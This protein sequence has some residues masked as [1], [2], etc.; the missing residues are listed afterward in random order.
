MSPSWRDVG[1][2]ALAP[3]SVS[4]LRFAR[5]WHPRLALKAVVPCAPGS[6]IWRAALETMRTLLA[7]PSWQGCDLSV[8]L[9]NHFVRYAVVPGDPGL[10]TP[11]ERTAFAEIAFEKVFGG[12]CADW[13]LRVSPA[14]GA[15][16]TLASGVDRALLA[17]LRDTCGGKARLKAIR[18]YLMCAFNPLRNA[19]NGEA[20]ALALVEPGRVTLALTA[21]S[22]WA[23]V[24]SRAAAQPDG[25]ALQQMLAEQCALS[26]LEARGR[27]WLHDLTGVCSLAPGSAW[28]VAA[29]KLPAAAESA[30]TQFGLA[31]C[32][33]A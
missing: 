4:A 23:S 21:R 27:L 28:N 26:G 19:L 15:E 8:V 12:L 20:S 6:L 24:A 30:G 31:A 1:V 22:Q 5:G 7:N 17:E 29:L 32:G 2:I 14:Q 11:M 9:S 16:P 13:E 18:P 10:R 33:V 25:A 3:D